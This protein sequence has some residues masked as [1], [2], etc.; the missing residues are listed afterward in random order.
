KLCLASSTPTTSAQIGASA[1]M[2]R[3][4]LN[5]PGGCTFE[6]V[7]NSTGAFW[8]VLDAG[9]GLAA[10][11]EGVFRCASHPTSPVIAALN[12]AQRQNSVR[13]FE[14]AVLRIAGTAFGELQ[15]QEPSRETRISKRK[16]PPP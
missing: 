7:C 12:R 13:A 6:T 5:L 16:S 3:T 2:P 10:A 9:S 14:V 15:S 8:P 1:P 11:D 4:L